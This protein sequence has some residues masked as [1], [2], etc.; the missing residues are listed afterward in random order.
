[1]TPRTKNII[2]A[3]AGLQIALIIG[4][5]SLPAFMN[6]VFESMVPAQYYLYFPDAVIDLMGKRADQL[7]DVAVADVDAQN[8]LNSDIGLAN[9]A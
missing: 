1:M 2:I 4:V 6:N 9:V 8:L 7:P 3:V 5:V